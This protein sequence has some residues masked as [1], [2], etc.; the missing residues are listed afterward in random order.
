MSNILFKNAKLV[1][2]GFASLQ[3]G[4]DVLVKDKHVHTVFSSPSELP[5]TK[6]IDVAGQTL[7]PSL[8][9]AHA[10]ITGLNLSPK[11]ILTLHLRLS[12]PVRT[13]CGTA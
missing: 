13:I 7:M 9:D 11:N 1:L 10:H 5:N 2:D 4:F 6:I 12:W 3:A 8:I